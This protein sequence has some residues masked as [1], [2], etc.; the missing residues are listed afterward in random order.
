VAVLIF[1]CSVHAAAVVRTASGANP[2]AIQATVDQFRTD[3]SL[4]GGINAPA[5]GPLGSGR[6]EI[7]WDGVPGTASSPNLF[8]GDFFNNNSKRGIVLTTTG[9]NTGMVVS[10]NSIPGDPNDPVRFG[11][12]DPSYRT[13]FQAFSAQKLFATRGTTSY[14]SSFRVPAFPDA[15]ATVFGFGVVFADV[16]VAGASRIEYFDAGDNLLGSFDAPVANGGLSFLGVFF[17]A[18]ERVARVRVF[19]G[20]AAL[21]PGVL[22]DATHDVVAVDDFFYS[23][24]IPAPGSLAL[25]ALGGAVAV[26]RRR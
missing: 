5:S 6:R 18:G 14:D 13:T 9:A 1:A 4:G 11:D 24:P 15:P 12:I 21:A 8:P 25:L 2:A 3:I 7:N 16:D 22:D 17:N 20:N 10:Q 23:E 26:R 19:T